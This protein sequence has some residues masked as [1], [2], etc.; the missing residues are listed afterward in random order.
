V[1]GGKGVSTSRGKAW[2]RRHSLW[3]LWTFAL[4]FFSWIA[5]AYIGIR[6]RH[7]RW[8]LW[9][10]LY[11]SPLIVV[12]VLVNIPQTWYNAV[13]SM[14]FLLCP[15][16]IIHAFL[17][18]KEYLLRLDLIMRETGDVSIT[19]LG[20]GWEWRHS[21]WILW[22][23]TLGYFSWIAF[24]YVAFRARRVRWLL[25]GAAYLCVYLATFLVDLQS[26]VGEIVTG[27]SIVVGIIS[28]VHA[29]AIRSDYLVRLERRL[30]EGAGERPLL[31]NPFEAEY[32]RRIAEQS[33]AESQEQDVSTP[34]AKP[35]DTE[36]P[37]KGSATSPH[38]DED[39][40]QTAVPSNEASSET[41]SLPPSEPAPKQQA[42][43]P[44]E[45][46]AGT[47]S[48]GPAARHTRQPVEVSVSNVSRAERGST[49][50]AVAETYP[51]PIAY[52][53]SLLEG[54]WDP[55]DRYREQLRH[56]ENMLAFLGSVSLA[57]L[58]DGHY[59]KAQLD[60]KVPWQGGISFGAW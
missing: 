35:A 28:T 39:P 25:W 41:P 58:D 43:A 44:T 40:A 4:G 5:F 13:L 1:L 22:T 8:T 49:L 56:A 20:R 42:D 31:P 48:E 46:Q 14:Y 33:L 15:I 16:S 29:F 32:Q 38:E 53:W 11:A 10:A 23:L 57:L 24:L 59:E 34:H 30:Q 52:S 50:E 51:L 26:Q 27:L 21:L 6:A 54:V 60:L 18:R 7:P 19:S 36:A 2:E 17:V 12:A 9:A 47:Q 3:I 37:P 55:R 45:A